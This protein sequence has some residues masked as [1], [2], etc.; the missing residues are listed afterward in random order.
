MNLRIKLYAIMPHLLSKS[1]TILFHE[2]L[3]LLK[4]NI[5]FLSTV[6]ILSL[7]LVAEFIRKYNG[8]VY[9]AKKEEKSWVSN[10]WS[11]F[12]FLASASHTWLISISLI[13]FAIFL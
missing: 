8:Q 9:L 12:L 2:L 6:L 11:I 1:A 10:A 5:L 13:L 7:N 4:F 3:N